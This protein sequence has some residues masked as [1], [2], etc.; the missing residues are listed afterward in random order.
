M[1]SEGMLAVSVLDTTRSGGKAPNI[2][3]FL[4]RQGA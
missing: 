1:L 3:V 2:P 4:K